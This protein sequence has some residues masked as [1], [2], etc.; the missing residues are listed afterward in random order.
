ME[1]MTCSPHP[2]T[3]WLLTGL[4]AMLCL[5]PLTAMAQSG[6]WRERLAARQSDSAGTSLYN[7]TMAGLERDYLLHAP[8]VARQANTKLPLVIVLHGTYGTGQKME[9]GLGFDRY[10]DRDG[11]FVAYPDA[12]REAGQR[13]T[14]RWNDGRDTLASS[15]LGIDDVAF[16]A[17]LIDDIAAHYPIDTRRVFVTGASNG[18]IMAYRLGCQLHGRIRAIA[19]V[20]GNVATLLQGDCRPDPGLSVL[21]ING[22]QDPFV[23][24]HGG[25]VC[26]NVN[27]RFCEGGQVLSH[28]RSISYFARANGCEAQ[29]A[30]SH[31]PT[32]VDD[33][34]RVEQFSYGGCQNGARV[35]ALVVHGMGHTWAPRSGQLPSAGP[36]TG[37]LDA[38]AE[39]TAFFMSLR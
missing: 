26:Q 23:P 11:F 10:A 35:G 13:Q 37:N 34:T 1:F 25:E 3:R 8:P 16:I 24:L 9:L 31:R 29:P 22:D 15:R 39:I 6:G 36:G 19:P 5:I 30:A 18:G 14:T 28:D 27:K 2:V 12:Y 38:T 17:R 4:L 32:S 20:I 7:L 21:S 33:G